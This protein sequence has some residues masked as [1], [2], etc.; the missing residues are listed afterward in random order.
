LN[1]KPFR[2]FESRLELAINYTRCVYCTITSKD[3]LKKLLKREG[4]SKIYGSNVLL[5][6]NEFETYFLKVVDFISIFINSF[7]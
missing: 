1:R 5:N 2:I 7:C 4:I 3:C 6:L